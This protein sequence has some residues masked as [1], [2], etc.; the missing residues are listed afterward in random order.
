MLSW[1]AKIYK[2]QEGTYEDGNEFIERDEHTLLIKLVFCHFYFSF[3]A[4]GACNVLSSMS[5]SDK[6][7]GCTVSGG[8]NFVSA[9]TYYGF[10]QSVPINVIVSKDC[11]LVDKHRFKENFAIVKVHG[12]DRNDASLHALSYCDEI[13]SSYVHG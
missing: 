5:P 6:S 1:N 2:T 3:K 12:N 13:G 9:M 8:R 7:K 4:R 10:R 11:P